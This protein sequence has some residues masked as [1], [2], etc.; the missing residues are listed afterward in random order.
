MEPLFKQLGELPKRFVALSSGAKLALGAVLV[1]GVGVVT[2]ATIFTSAN[3][4]QYAYTNLSTDDSAEISAQLK[5]AGVPFRFEAGGGKAF[6]AQARVE[7]D[8]D[9]E[10]ETFGSQRGDRVHEAAICRDHADVVTRQLDAVTC[11]HRADHQHLHAGALL[12]VFPRTN[13]ERFSRSD[14]IED[15]DPAM[16]HGQRLHQAMA[17]GVALEHGAH[18]AGAHHRAEGRD[19]GGV[20]SLREL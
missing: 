9:L 12:K 11:A 8:V 1:L 19:V 14:H 6:P 4:Y 20:G 2:A 13:G 17:V 5:V 10:L 3:D 18:A 7:V 16:G 15:V